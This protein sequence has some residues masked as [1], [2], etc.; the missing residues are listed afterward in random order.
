MS[1][2]SLP[3]A[4]ISM[5]PARPGRKP[6][7][8]EGLFRSVRWRPATRIIATRFPPIDLYERISPDP[9]VWE[10]LIEAEMLVNPRLRD[11]IGEIS[12]VPREERISGEGASW[13]MA[14]FT[15]VNPKGS[16]FADGTYGVYYA[17]DVLTTA[18]AETAWHFGRLAAD[19]GD[20][21][22]YEDMRVL[23]GDI[24]GELV[25]LERAD[26]AF[27]DPLLDPNSYVAS[28]A[29]GRA[30][31]E[32][33]R[34][35]IHYGSVRRSGGRCVALFRPKAARPP[36]QAGVVKYHWDGERVR[37]YYDYAR[38]LWVEL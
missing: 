25:D 7:V 29:F 10:A 20:G 6:H 4:N 9:K 35:G 26:A 12:L 17:A 21:P 31:R 15:H 36:V 27:R 37:R 38:E 33:G 3:S 16:R 34:D 14:A 8:A 24:D 5:P 18:I 22:R 28:Q 2:I 32:E 1:P 30:L 19:S 23:R 11:E 13:V